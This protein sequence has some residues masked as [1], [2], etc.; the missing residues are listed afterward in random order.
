VAYNFQTETNKIKLLTEYENVTQK[1]YLARH[2]LHIGIVLFENFTWIFLDAGLGVMDQFR[3]LGAHP[4]LRRLISSC[5]YTLR[6]LRTPVTSLD[7]L[8][9][10]I[11]AAIENYAK[12]T[13]RETEHRLDI[14]RAKKG[15]H[16]E[17]VQHP[18]AL[19]IKLPELHF[20]I[21]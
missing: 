21:P 9:P 17:V 1:F 18:A 6:T 5:G 11:V 12:N 2:A 10:I 15:A 3:G 14:L 7:E 8:K 20:H 16:V 19:I 13:W 4:I